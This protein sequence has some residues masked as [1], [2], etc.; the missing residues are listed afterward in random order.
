MWQPAFL[1]LLLYTA[2]SAT[3]AAN[4]AVGK[5]LAD[6]EHNYAEFNLSHVAV[7]GVNG[8]DIYLAGANVLYQLDSSLRVKHRVDTGK[9]ID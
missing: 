6:F 9:C 3:S 7:D 1:L 8:G 2:N 4:S 5:I